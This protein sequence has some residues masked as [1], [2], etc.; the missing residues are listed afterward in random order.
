[1]KTVL[2]LPTVHVELDDRMTWTH[3]GER[4]R[5]QLIRWKDDGRHQLGV[6]KPYDG[7]MHDVTTFAQDEHEAQQ[8]MLILLATEWPAMLA[9]IDEEA[10]RHEDAQREMDGRAA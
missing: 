8:R 4:F 5:V 9:L 6:E 2:G 1:M 3:R 7:S 10:K